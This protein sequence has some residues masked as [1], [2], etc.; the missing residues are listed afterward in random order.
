MCSDYQSGG[1]NT[2][3][4]CKNNGCTHSLLNLRAS[5]KKIKCW[6]NF[7]IGPLRVSCG[8][9][10]HHGTRDG[11]QLWYDPWQHR[12]L[13]SEAWRRGLY[14]GRCYRVQH[15]NGSKQKNPKSNQ[16]NVRNWKLASLKFCVFP[17]LSSWPSHPFPRI[18]NHCNLKELKSYLSSGGGKCLFNMPNTRVM[19]GGQRC[20][21]GYLED[22]E[23][24]DCGEEE[25]FVCC[26][27]WILQYCSICIIPTY[28]T[29]SQGS[30]VLTPLIL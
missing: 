5:P 8:C 23:E 22:G 15:T 20:G 24:C 11:P 6:F 19:Y 9:S 25:V 4:E 16:A 12:L 27:S 26:V 3:R 29:F 30:Q 18:F 1:V 14:H 7:W 17:S 2:V 10:R 28:S 13:P 21:N